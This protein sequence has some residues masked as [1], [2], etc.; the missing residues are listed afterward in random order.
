[1][2][3]QLSKT[4][5]LRALYA[6]A[7]RDGIL[8]LWRV[9]RISGTEKLSATS[10]IACAGLAGGVAGMIG[11]P[12]EVVLVR[13]CADGAR[14]PAQRFAYVNAFNG[15]VRIGREEGLRAFYKGLGPNIV[16]SMLMNVSQIAVYTEVKNRLATSRLNL[17]D[18]VPSHILASLTAGTVA[19][20]VCAPADV[21]KSRMQNASAT[22]GKAPSLL[23]TIGDSLKK[24]GPGFLMKGWT[25]AWLRL[26]KRTGLDRAVDRIRQ[27]IQKSQSNGGPLD[28]DQPVLN[29]QQLLDKTQDP[30]A[31]S[32]TPRDSTPAVQFQTLSPLAQGQLPVL[33]QSNLTPSSTSVDFSGRGGTD[34]SF[35]LDN[36]E[37]PLQLLA[38]AS[39]LPDSQP[40]LS[41]TTPSLLPAAAS[42]APGPMRD[43]SGSQDLRTF[44]GPFYPHLD[45]GEDIDPIDMGFVTQKEADVLFT[46]F[47]QHLSHTRWGL[48]PA[49]HTSDFVRKRSAFLFTSILAACALFLPLTA[50][51]SKRLPVHCKNLAH[52]VMANRKRSPEI[53]LA[54]MVNIPWMSPGKHWADDE[55]CTYTAMALTVAMDLSLNKHVIP[56]P[57]GSQDSIRK[58]L[59][60]AII[61]HH[62]PPYLEI[63]VTHT[64][65][66]MYS[67]VINHP[68]APIEVKRFH[69]AGLSSSLK[70]MRT[71]VQG[72]GQLKSMPSN[73]A[74][75]VSFAACFALSLSTMAAGSSLSL[76]PSIR[77]LIEETAD[78]LERI[79]TTPAH[80]KGTSA[81]YGRHLREVVRN[82][83][84]KINMQ[85]GKGQPGPQPMAQD[86]FFETPG[87]RHTQQSNQ[88]Q[89]LAGLLSFEP[90]L[91]SA[92]S[93]H[94]IAEVIDNAG[95]ELQTCLYSFPVD[96][97]TWLEWQDFFHLDP[98][99]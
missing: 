37:N 54:F 71:A 42:S 21:L 12:A 35:A 84:E 94:Q 43:E 26:A 27:E 92:M 90:L 63:L 8:S 95:D 41:S 49:V 57:N 75:M 14:V 52:H 56:S 53:V 74:I 86:P 61:E 17:K 28:D 32:A 62:L 60:L 46:F 40:Q 9:Q 77:V 11:N 3:V 83:S 25:P 51:L 47:Y 6:F 31:R 39:N 10:T 22:N 72:E 79:G 50:A 78:V 87:Q 58:D 66:S 20:T 96:D 23:Q 85:G 82:T 33:P 88:D 64:R 48:D 91:F 24:E 81:L 38:H 69:T 99:A 97:N 68:T 1:M 45:V 2:Q 55:T 16:R 76:A 34:D 44:F 4:P 80:R 30:L 13:M 70:V 67:S 93:D 7:T 5:T 36:A 73:T 18:N 98:L 59:K 29:L 65:L 15:L 89:N 19:T